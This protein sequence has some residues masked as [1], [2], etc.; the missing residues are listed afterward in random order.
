MLGTVVCI[1]ERAVIPGRER[2]V[3]NLLKKLQV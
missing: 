2:M 3:L 1:T